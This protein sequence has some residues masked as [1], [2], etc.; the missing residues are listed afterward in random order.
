[1]S[2]VISKN[3]KVFDACGFKSWSDISA[4]R[5]YQYLDSLRDGGRG[6]SS[7]TFN[8][9]LRAIKQFCK[10]M[11]MEG[12]ASVSPVA[13]LKAL[14]VRTDRRHDRRALTGEELKRLLDAASSGGVHHAMTGPERRLLYLL[15][16][17]TGLRWSEL[18]SLTKNS[19]DLDGN[20]PTVKVDATYSK[21]KREDVLPLRPGTVEE[22]KGYLAMKLPTAPAFSMWRQCGSNMLR[23]DLETAGID[24]VDE[25]GRYADFHSL[26][27]TFLTNLAMSGVH[28]KIAQSLARHSDI[29]LTM[30]RYTHILLETQSDA[31]KVL[32]ELNGDVQEA[33][34]KSL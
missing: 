20:P 2:Q 33:V 8:Q 1:V 17:E 19:F 30:N 25:N 6:V 12:R 15:A 3:K 28:P 4:N 34:V 23:Q 32:P 11:V 24:Y 10:W 29:N 31:L 13:H 16:V 26:R 9:H 21:H 14:N 5:V 27:H 7:E 18:R 22:L